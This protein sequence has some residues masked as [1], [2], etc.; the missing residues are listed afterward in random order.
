[1]KI[2]ICCNDSYEKGWI[3]IL[4]LLSH[5]WKGFWKSEMVKIN[6]QVS[7]RDVI[8]KAGISK[9]TAHGMKKDYN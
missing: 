6:S 9:W 7:M 3:L 4:K 8:D 1:M 5:I 2:C